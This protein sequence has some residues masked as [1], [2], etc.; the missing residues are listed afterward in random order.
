MLEQLPYIIGWYDSSVLYADYLA[1]NMIERL[2]ELGVLERCIVI[3]TPI[4]V[5]AS[6]SMGGCCMVRPSLTR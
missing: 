3:I 4:T 2:K 6:C 5:K 1:Q